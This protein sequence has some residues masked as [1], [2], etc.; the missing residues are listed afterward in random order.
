M[1]AAHVVQGWFTLDRDITAHEDGT[2]TV[3]PETAQALAQVVDQFSAALSAR[4][5]VPALAA[6]G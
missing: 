2:V 6:A 5:A 3:A 1:G 4:P